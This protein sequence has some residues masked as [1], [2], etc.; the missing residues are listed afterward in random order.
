[1]NAPSLAAQSGNPRSRCVRLCGAKEGAGAGSADA[2]SRLAQLHKCEGKCGSAECVLMRHTIMLP[3]LA[4]A[5][6]FSLSLLLGVPCSPR[7]SGFSFSDSVI[8]FFFIFFFSFRLL[9]TQVESLLLLVV[10][11]ACSQFPI[12][13]RGTVMRLTAGIYRAV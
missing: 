2:Q 8:L 6:S 13:L 1:V 12:E 11:F 3:S 5:L 7:G 9:F 4:L 10:A